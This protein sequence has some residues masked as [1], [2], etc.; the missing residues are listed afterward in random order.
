VLLAF[1]SPFVLDG[2]SP[3][4]GL[5]AFCALED[6]QRTA[7]RVLTGRERAAGTMPV[8]ISMRGAA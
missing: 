7:A 4:A 2:L 1:G 6:F 5:C 8:K 3:S